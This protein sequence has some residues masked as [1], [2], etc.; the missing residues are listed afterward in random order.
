MRRGFIVV[1]DGNARPG[2]MRDELLTEIKKEFVEVGANPTL[3]RI[4]RRK[5]SA[6]N[7]SKGLRTTFPN[8]FSV[9]IDIQSSPSH[10]CNDVFKVGFCRALGSPV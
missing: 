3:A 1:I 10:L 8:Y 2:D 4:V 9:S 5:T 6:A 7:D